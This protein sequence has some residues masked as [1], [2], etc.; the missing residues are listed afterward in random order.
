MSKKRTQQIP[1]FSKSISDFITMME[2]TKKDYQ[3]NYEE[4]GRLD[5]LTQDYLHK[6]E[7]D[8]LNYR[9]RAK[10]ATKLASCR[11]SRREHKDMV[12]VLEPL[13]NFMESD[14]GKSLL[15][16]LRE[17]LGKTRKVEGRMGNRVYITR[18]LDET[19]GVT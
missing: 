14:K 10:V 1:Q 11:Q 3:W 17:A 6:L 5:L 12:E 19:K 8:N 16:L 2:D 13:V 7:L 18:V 9:E 15:N 4:V